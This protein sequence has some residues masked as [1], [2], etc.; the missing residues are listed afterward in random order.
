MFIGELKNE[1]IKPYRKKYDLYIFF[2]NSIAEFKE[3]LLKLKI[4]KRSILI[5]ENLTA[6]FIEE[7]IHHVIDIIYSKCD[8]ERIAE[9]IENT[10][11][12]FLSDEK[13]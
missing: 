8:I 7:S 2:S 5:T 13:E 11:M 12:R 4:P 9:R 6:A 3:L 1:D 10:Y